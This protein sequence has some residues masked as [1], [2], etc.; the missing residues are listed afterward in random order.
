MDTPGKVAHHP[1]SEP[2][3]LNHHLLLQTEIWHDMSAFQQK[4]QMTLAYI[5]CEKP[6]RKSNYDT[7]TDCK[8]MSTLEIV[9]VLH[10]CFNG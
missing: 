4:G 8:K 1:E 5:I 9:H 10:D 2:P 6:L 3:P 7:R